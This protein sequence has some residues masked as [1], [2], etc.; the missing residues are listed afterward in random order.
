MPNHTFKVSAGK[1]RVQ[2]KP[3]QFRVGDKVKV[4]FGKGRTDARIIE[5][6][7]PIGV[8]G[9]R[10]VRIQLIKPK[11]DLEMS[12]EVPIEDLVAS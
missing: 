9:R 1:S 12:F 5:D 10:L 2:S 11:D 4:R 6:R 7:G 3:R 8:K